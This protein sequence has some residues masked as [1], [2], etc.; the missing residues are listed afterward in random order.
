MDAVMIRTVT[1]NFLQCGKFMQNVTYNYT[2]LTNA[3][4]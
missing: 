3:V 4:K 1:N 2:L